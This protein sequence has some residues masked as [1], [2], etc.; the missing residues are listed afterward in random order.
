MV[1]SFRSERSFTPIAA[2]KRPDI[3]SRAFQRNSSLCLDQWSHSARERDG[4]H[5]RRLRGQSAPGVDLQYAGHTRG[6]RGLADPG[7]PEEDSPGHRQSLVLR[8]LES[9]PKS[10]VVTS[11]SRVLDV[12]L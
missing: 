10:R 5:G 9:M 12:P 11:E 8:P 4:A 3:Q 2:L 1:V 7:Y 6:M